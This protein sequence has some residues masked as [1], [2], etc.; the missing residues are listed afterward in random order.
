MP[1][2]ETILGIAV[3]ALTVK[4]ILDYLAINYLFHKLHENAELW[5]K[6]Q[7]WETTVM[8]ILENDSP[9]DIRARML[10]ID[11]EMKEHMSRHTFVSEDIKL[12][13]Y[14]LE[15]EVSE[16]SARLERYHHAKQTST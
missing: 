16:Q 2:L 3:I 6:L 10:R 1:S 5:R 8:D 13:V 4:T 11:S 12:R 14:A 7:E 9:P 15:R